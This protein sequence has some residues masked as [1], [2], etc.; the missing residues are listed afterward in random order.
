VVKKVLCA[1]LCAV[2]FS[3]TDCVIAQQPGKFPRIAFLGAGS[4]SGPSS[5]RE[6]FLQGLRELGYTEGENIQIVY[7]YA[8]GDSGRLPDLAAELV[9]LKVDVI[10][11]A[12]ALSAS[13]AKNATKTIPIVMAGSDPVGG[14]LVDTL[15]QPGGNLTGLTVPSPELAGKQL[16]LLKE[17]F[18]KSSRIAVLRNPASP[19]AKPQ[20]KEI[21]R[22]GRSLGLQLSILDAQGL[23]DFDKVFAI[24][25]QDSVQAVS[26][27]SSAIFVVH[28]NQ[29]VDFSSKARLPTIYPQSDFVSAGGLMSY[30]SV[31]LELWRRTAVI[32][33]KILKGVKPADLPVE[34]PTKFELVINLRTAKQIGL[35]IPPN[36]LAKAD[37]VI[38]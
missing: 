26:V 38:K 35:T 33:D 36:V 23:K 5:A 30:G 1:A 3:A 9:R 16:E 27:L 15:A 19:V 6:Y 4:S 2:L 37:R 13:A 34:Q 18:P 11:V 8:E 29:L 32:V 25:K 14:G 7:R 21:E 31:R 20:L 24:M 28:S 10:V 17:T 12:S 22:A